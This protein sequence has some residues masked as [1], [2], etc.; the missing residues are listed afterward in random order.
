MARNLIRFTGRF[1]RPSNE[2]PRKGRKPERV[3]GEK[4]KF[5]HNPFQ[6]RNGKQKRTSPENVKT[7]MKGK[8]SQPQDS[9]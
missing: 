4:Q 8:I 7:E 1:S 2:N 9:A 5:F 3:V 6:K